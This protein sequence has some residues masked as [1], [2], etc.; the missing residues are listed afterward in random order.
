MLREGNWTRWVRNS[1]LHA[2]AVSLQE[3]TSPLNLGSLTHMWGDSDCPS[4][5]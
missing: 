5:L 2:S 4:G 3:G 1:V